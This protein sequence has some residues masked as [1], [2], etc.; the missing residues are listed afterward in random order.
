MSWWNTLVAPVAGLFTK[1]LDI[2][3]DFVPDKDLALKV[4]AALSQRIAEIAHGEY[5]TLVKTQGGIIV[6]EAKGDSWLQR[7]WRPVIMMI[8]GTIV[9]NNYIVAP[10]IELLFGAKYKLVLEIP[11]DMW[12]LLKLGLSGYVVG[13]SLEKIA[14]SAGGAKGILSKIVGGNGS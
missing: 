12:G 3:D 14:G 4:K 2:V 9:A 10:Y 1:A 5:A 11:A 13:R 7:N 6:A 8:F